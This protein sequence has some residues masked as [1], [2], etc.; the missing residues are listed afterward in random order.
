MRSSVLVGEKRNATEDFPGEGK[1]ELMIVVVKQISSIV[2]Q[3]KYTS[4]RVEI[5]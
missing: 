2:V 1:L 3:D 5:N 4:K